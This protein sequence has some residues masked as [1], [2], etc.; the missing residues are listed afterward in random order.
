MCKSIFIAIPKTPKAVDCDKHRIISL[1]SQMTKVLLR[2]LLN[3]ARNKIKDKVSEVQYGFRPGK[4]TRNAMFI[5]RMMA[6]RAIEMQK[7]LYLCF[8]DYEKAFDKVHHLEMIK[9]LEEISLDSKDIRIMTNL[10]WKNKA[11]LRVGNELTDWMEIKRGVRQG[12]VWSPDLFALYGEKIMENIEDD[13]GVI[14]GGRNINNIRYA[15]DTVL[16]ADSEEKLQR[17]LSKLS[18]A[19]KEK[20]LS[21]NLKKTKVLVASRNEN[22]PVCNLTLENDGTIVN[23]KQVQE[24]EYLRSF[25]TADVRSDREI[26]KR[27][28]LAKT[29]F[30]NMKTFLANR[31]LDLGI[32][33]QVMKT[34]IWSKMLYGCESWTLSKEMER[35]LEAAEMWMYRRMLRTSWKDFK[36]NEEILRIA[37]TRREILREIKSRQ[38]S[39]LGH[40]MRHGDMEKLVLT[41]KIHGVRGRGRPRKTFMDNFEELGEPANQILHQTSDRSSWRKLKNDIVKQRV[42]KPRLHK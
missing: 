7:D 23:I 22:P 2:I 40:I 25:I 19:S 38:M 17:L 34:Y 39:F 12:C 24:F 6:E 28:G 9:L 33:K 35:R 42:K 20:G 29:S 8:V 1:M 4:G 15:D 11:A 18:L 30:N 31:K 10:Y 36:T 5:V 27:I 21:I 13:E 32:R 3:R 14:I 16:I 41:G 37:K 26:K